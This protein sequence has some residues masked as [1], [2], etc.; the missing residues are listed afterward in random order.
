MEG[1]RRHRLPRDAADMI[2]LLRFDSFVLDELIV[3]HNEEFAPDKEGEPDYSISIDYNLLKREGLPSFLIRMLVDLSPRD[4]CKAC[5]F[6]RLRVVMVG[7]FSFPPDTPEDRVRQ[8]TPLNQLAML[9]GT[10]RGVVANITG[11]G[12]SGVFVLPSVN[13]HEICRAKAA[14][15]EAAEQAASSKPRRRRRVAASHNG[16][17]ALGESVDK[18]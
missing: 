1:P 9:Y 10:A 4:G 7:F 3:E 16:A 14:E 18:A 15:A 5:S 2:A 17:G 8:L 11:M 6:R 13:F 12:R